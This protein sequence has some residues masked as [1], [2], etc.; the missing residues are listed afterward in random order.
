MLLRD[1]PRHG[2]LVSTAY[3]LSLFVLAT[4]I[5]AQSAEA[6]PGKAS[7]RRTGYLCVEEKAPYTRYHNKRKRQR[8]RKGF[9]PYSFLSS[10]GVQQEIN[11]YVAN[12]AGILSGPIGPQGEK[13]ESGD[14]GPQGIQGEAG[15]IGPQGPIG[16]TGAA[17]VQGPAGDTG[18]IG[19]QGE[20]G[21][22]GPQGPEGATGAVGAT[23]AEG[24][25]GSQGATGAQGPQG[26]Q[27][28]QGPQ[29]PQGESGTV[30]INICYSKSAEAHVKEDEGSNIMLHCNDPY[31]E[32]S[33]QHGF[34]IT[35]SDIV[36]IPQEFTQLYTHP[37]YRVVFE[38]PTGASLSVHGFSGEGAANLTI[39]C[40][41]RAP[42][43]ETDS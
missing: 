34:S 21:A 15:P 36:A 4:G 23:G 25:T 3:A 38:Y 6:A 27:G 31:T 19:P 40:C 28:A 30:D 22:I 24:P 18:A 14:Q 41:P 32:Y 43:I 12:N 35:G 8:C 29:G 20:T 13:G 37:I 10:A 5:S 16:E 2:S 26:S 11:S 33:L 17:G 9:V 42:S 7:S 39:V 1:F